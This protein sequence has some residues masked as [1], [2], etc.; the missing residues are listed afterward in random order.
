M[1]R[2][3]DPFTL[4]VGEV[5]LSGEVRGITMIDQRLNEAGKMGLKTVVAPEASLG[6]VKASDVKVVGVKTLSEALE[7]LLRGFS[8]TIHIFP[9]TETP[10]KAA[11]RRPFRPAL[12]TQFQ[13][14]LDLP[15]MLILQFTLPVVEQI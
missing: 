4:V 3:V 2:P 13:V 9:V 8:S 1:N 14:E 6:R 15:G 7:Y 10:F 5:G 12:V 11:D